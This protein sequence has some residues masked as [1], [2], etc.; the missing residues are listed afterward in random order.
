MSAD[1]QDIISID[2]KDI[3]ALCNNNNI[4]YLQT[5]SDELCEL[6][7]IIPIEKKKTDNFNALFMVFDLQGKVT[8]AVTQKCKKL[9]KKITAN[10]DTTNYNKMDR[11]MV[12][13]ILFRYAVS[14][15]Y[16]D[17]C[18]IM[19]NMMREAC[20]NGVKLFTFS[21]D[22]RFGFYDKHSTVTYKNGTIYS[23]NE[24][25]LTFI[26]NNIASQYY[27]TI[28]FD[29]DLCNLRICFVIQ[30][31]DL[32][33]ITFTFDANGELEI[34]PIRKEKKDNSTIYST[35]TDK[36]VLDNIRKYLF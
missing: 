9:M 19:I 22:K 17:E 11:I 7:I 5:S 31:Y 18:D 26:R 6:S 20:Y 16:A 10:N 30:E 21:A 36:Y 34:L 24:Y 8:H 12:N 29:C 2:Y 33:S 13:K 25:L 23:S 15:G 14:Y 27:N 1:I 35:V 32:D 28:N 4:V 3:V